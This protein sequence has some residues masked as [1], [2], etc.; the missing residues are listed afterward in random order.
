MKTFSRFDAA[1]YLETEEDIAAYLEA[2]VAENPGDAKAVL[3]ALGV[4]ARAG[5]MSKLAKDANMTREGLYKALSDNGNPS[6]ANVIA[7]SNAL[8][9]EVSFKPAQAPV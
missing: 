1:D 9:L 2:V 6:F 8:G 5:N 7:V 3:R 4:A